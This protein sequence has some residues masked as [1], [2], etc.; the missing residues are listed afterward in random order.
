MAT[1]KRCSGSMRRAVT[2]NLGRGR[3]PADVCASMCRSKM[4]YG[5]IQ[6]LGSMHIPCR[7]VYVHHDFRLQG[8]EAPTF[9][10]SLQVS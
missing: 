10:M 1:A 6:A 3:R 4:S 2:N 8:R 7:H 9:A 5:H